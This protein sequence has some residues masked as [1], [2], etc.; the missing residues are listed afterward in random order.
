MLI[1]HSVLALSSVVLLAARPRSSR[2]TLAILLLAVVDVAFGASLAPAIGA[3]LPLLT[4]LV[5]AFTLAA[6]ADS[7]GLSA[8]GAALLVRCSRGSGVTLY[9]LVCLLVAVL[10]AVVSLDGAVVLM[11]PL[12]RAL[13][14]SFRAPFA[15]LFLGVVVVAN[16]FS[17]AVPQGNPTNLLVL[18]LSGLSAGAFATHMFAPGT[19]AAV[20][21]ALAVAWSQRAPLAEA[22]L[23]PAGGADSLSREER[24]A[25][26][27]LGLAGIAAWLSPL[28]GVAPWWPFSAAVGLS[29]LL[30][31]RRPKLRVPWRVAAQLGGLVVAVR[32]TAPAEVLLPGRGLL[33]LLATALAVGGV[34]ALAN[35]LPVSVAAQAFTGAGPVAYAVSIG[36]AA[37]ALAT[38]Q[39]SVATVIARDLAG[40][41][42]PRL[43]LRRLAPLAAIGVVLATVVLWATL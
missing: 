30:V 29:L 28:L 27:A 6:L 13:Q 12:V 41:D 35:N 37:G 42:A 18:E 24:S 19:A 7:S 10:T 1:F 4:F 2:V 31:P 21:C 36:L 39:G 9:A 20:V 3:V 38:P 22:T 32:A 14:R 34:A 23:A 40:A 8:R 16:V 15:P 11:V 43:P 33:T 26:A 25:L 5:A 17:L